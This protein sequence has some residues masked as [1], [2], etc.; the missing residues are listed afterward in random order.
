M[1]HS[2]CLIAAWNNFYAVM[3]SQGLFLKALI[4]MGKCI[5]W[6]YPLLLHKL[7]EI[8]M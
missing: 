8:S 6:Q 3:F 1:K 5:H 2:F 4:C 7:L